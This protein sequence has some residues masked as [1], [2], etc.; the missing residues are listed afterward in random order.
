MKN[1]RVQSAAK[2]DLDVCYYPAQRPKGL[3]QILHGMQEHKE[4]YDDF[5]CFLA[6]NG[7]SVLIHDHLGHGRST[8]PEHPLGDMVSCETILGDIDRVRRSVDFAGPYTCF[9]HSMGSFLARDY[10]ADHPVDRLILMGTGMQSA[11]TLRLMKG[12]LA[13]QKKGV[14]LPGIQKIL[15]AQLTRGFEQPWDWLSLDRENQRR[16]QQDPLCGQPFTREGYTAFCDLILK[17]LRPG[18]YERCTAKR[19]LILSGEHDTVGG[20][21]KGVAQVEARY[22][23]AGKQARSILY[24]NMAHEILQEQGRQ[25]VYDDILSFLS[26]PI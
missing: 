24:P 9:G 15:T 2:V 26:D 5:A 6:Q 20:F 16:Y 21:G 14:P 23:R 1:Y 17:M 8:S 22:R 18:T 19:I 4:R 13:F 7:Y 11:L 25:R 10:A 3:V 12:L